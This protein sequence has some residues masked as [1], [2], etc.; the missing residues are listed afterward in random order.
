MH[1]HMHIHA[2]AH[3]HAHTCAHMRTH[4]HTCAHMR[5]HAHTCAHTCTHMRTH[6]HTHVRIHSISGAVASLITRS[7]PGIGGP[8]ALATI[9]GSRAYHR[10]TGPQ[11]MKVAATCPSFHRVCRVSLISSAMA[12][13]LLGA[14]APIDY[15][16]GSGMNLLDIRSKRWCVYLCL[17]APCR[18]AFVWELFSP[19]VTVCELVRTC[20]GV[21]VSVEC[22]S[23]CS[24]AWV[25]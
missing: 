24:S 15:S 20:G 10:F 9:T 25:S 2:L 3:T 21:C 1:T 23:C 11:I 16:D 7:L 6:M 14:F 12:S 17:C 13:V 5:T 18:C 8:E 4:A 22:P 19:C